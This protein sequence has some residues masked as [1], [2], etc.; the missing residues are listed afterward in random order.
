[1][2]QARFATAFAMMLAAA[3][4]SANIAIPAIARDRD[5]Q[6]RDDVRRAVEAGEIRSLA[7]ILDAIRSRLPGEV[8]GV[9]IERKDGRWSYEFRVIDGRGRV[10]EVYVD[11]RSGEIERVKEK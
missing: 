11:P 2:P 1:M 8:A 3:A 4:L 6:R 5:E 10:F 9:E 7:D